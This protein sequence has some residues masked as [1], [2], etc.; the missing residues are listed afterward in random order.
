[1]MSYRDNPVFAFGFYAELSH[2]DVNLVSVADQDLVGQLERLKNDE[3]LDRTLLLLFADHGHRYNIRKLSIS[4]TDSIEFLF[5][6]LQ[7]K[8]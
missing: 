5:V 1:M 3:L 7:N 4:F 8:S 2:D 6:N